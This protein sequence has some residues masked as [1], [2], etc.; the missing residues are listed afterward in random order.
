M[1]QLPV[2]QRRNLQPAALGSLTAAQLS[3]GNLKSS[4]A[5][6]PQVNGSAS[7]RVT[8]QAN[9]TRWSDYT[10]VADPPI[11]W[12]PTPSPLAGPEIYSG[13]GV[14]MAQS[15]PA[16]GST[17]TMMGMQGIPQGAQMVMMQMPV[18]QAQPQL[19]PQGQGFFPMVAQQP[20]VVMMAPPAQP[21]QAPAGPMAPVQ[22]V[23]PD[24]AQAHSPGFTM[25]SDMQE[26]AANGGRQLFSEAMAVNTYEN[27]PLPA[28]VPSAGSALH[29]TGR[30][31]PCAW[32]WKPRGCNSHG[33]CSYCHLCPEGELKSRKK[34]K[35]AAIRMGALVPAGPDD[36]EHQPGGARGALKLNQ[37]I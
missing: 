6:S 12:P 17:Q 13:F 2:T 18:G 19:Q 29:G 23:S 20:P 3:P 10:P 8:P 11:L 26:A 16:H 1:A 27:V 9:R 22:D 32:F 7:F 37:L 36:G 15:I 33:E 14:P 25:V 35:V 24:Q 28:D 30:C 4:A 31:S 5:P 34:A 21:F